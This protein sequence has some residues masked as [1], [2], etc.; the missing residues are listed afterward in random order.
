MPAC[1]RFCS[2]GFLKACRP[3]LTLDSTAQH[4]SGSR[5]RGLARPH[6]LFEGPG[7]CCPILSLP[8]GDAL[9]KQKVRATGNELQ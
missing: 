1:G 8:Q 9:G 4:L 7:S 5:T 3:S 2:L 6:L